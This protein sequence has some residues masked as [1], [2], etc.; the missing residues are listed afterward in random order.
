[1][2]LGSLGGYFDGLA[3]SWLALDKIDRLYR[4]KECYV[5]WKVWRESQ[6]YRLI[7]LDLNGGS[8]EIE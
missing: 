7:R 4:I 2:A 3:L 5:I 8:D 1:M 6:G